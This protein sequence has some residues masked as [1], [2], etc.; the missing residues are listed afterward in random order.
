MIQEVEMDALLEASKALQELADAV[1]ESGADKQDVLGFQTTK[2]MVL[3]MMAIGE[4][5]GRLND[6]LDAVTGTVDG[7]RVVRTLSANNGDG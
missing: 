4:Q 1:V 3:T 7:R 6:S 5:L 2:V